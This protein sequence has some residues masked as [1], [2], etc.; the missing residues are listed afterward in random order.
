MFEPGAH[1]LY[2]KR[3]SHDLING[4]ILMEFEAI[5]IKTGVKWNHIFIAQ[6][7]TMYRRFLTRLTNKTR[8][9]YNRVLQTPFGQFQACRPQIICYKHR[10]Y[11]QVTQELQV[12]AE[13]REGAVVSI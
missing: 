3:D 7:S 12:H 1:L 4:L 2:D 11:E 6:I 5:F 9:T 8:L 10:S 13:Y